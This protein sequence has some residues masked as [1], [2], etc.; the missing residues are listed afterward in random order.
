MLFGILGFVMRRWD[1]PIPPLVMGVILGPMA[2]Q[3]FLT[4]M[5][6]NGNDVSIFVTRPVSAVILLLSAAMVIC[7]LWRSRHSP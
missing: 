6:S 3:Y 4:S 5:V 2:E 1:L 7:P